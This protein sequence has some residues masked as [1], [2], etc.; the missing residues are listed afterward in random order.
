MFTK[1]I[2]NL[3]LKKLKLYSKFV[4]PMQIDENF[5]KKQV[6]CETLNKIPLP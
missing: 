5:K 4:N 2:H 3:Q 6:T 1:T